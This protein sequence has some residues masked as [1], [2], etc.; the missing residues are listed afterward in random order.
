MS[1]TEKSCQVYT[2][3]KEVFKQFGKIVNIHKGTI[4]DH[5]GDAIY[6]FWEHGAS[7]LKEQAMLACQNALHRKALD[8]IR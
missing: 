7:P 4:K 8:H 2:L 1:E 3:M 5:V 6:A